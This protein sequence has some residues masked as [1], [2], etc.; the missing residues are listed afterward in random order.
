MQK[1]NNYILEESALVTSA[2][3]DFTKSLRPSSFVNMLIQIAWHHAEKL[4]FGMDFLHENR[5][6]WMLS[7]MYMKINSKPFWN[8][9]LHLRTWPKGIHRLFYLR[10]FE[11]SDDSDQKVALVTSEWLII[12]LKT[13]RPKLYQPENNIFQ[14]NKDRHAIDKLVPNLK[15]ENGEFDSFSNEVVYS[16]IDLNNHL[17][18]SRYVDWMMDTFDLE[19]LEKFICSDIV[20]NFIREVPFGAEVIIK[21]HKISPDEKYF[22][23]FQ[24]T[25]SSQ[26]YFRGQLCFT[27]N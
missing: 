11:V 14:E 13:K 22:F 3:T 21:R 12:D 24:S 17:T 7:R 9:T 1:S 4:G 8:N 2:D 5:L 23:E 10:D 20:I 19:F 15:T 18:T 16:D 26:T 6:V 25:D 27:A